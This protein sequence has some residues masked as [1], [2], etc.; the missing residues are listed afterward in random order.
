[1]QTL[2]FA[3]YVCNRGFQVAI[4]IQLELILSVKKCR[5]P[6]SLYSQIYIYSRSILLSFQV[7]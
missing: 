7:D 5:K 3:V 6:V 2:V 1:M 4:F